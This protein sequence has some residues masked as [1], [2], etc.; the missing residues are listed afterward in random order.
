MKAFL[1]KPRL[2]NPDIYDAFFGNE[3]HQLNALDP[4]RHL[5]GDGVLEL[6]EYCTQNQ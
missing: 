2:L 1:Q 3:M 6:L 5:G 4:G